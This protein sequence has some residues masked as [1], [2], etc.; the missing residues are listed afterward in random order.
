MKLIF[1]LIAF[2]L[3]SIRVYFSWS[4]KD[5]EKRGESVSSMVIKSDNYYEE[6][7]YSG[8]FQLTDDETGF[9]SI[10]P[11][12]Y[13]KFRK[14][15]E[16]VKAESNL[17]GEIEYRIYDGE[18]NLA[19]DKEGKKLIAEAIREMIVQGFDAKARMERIYKKG[20]SRALISEIDSMKTDQIK[21]IYLDRVFSSDSSLSEDLPAI[22]LKIGSLGSDNDKSLFL[23]R[24]PP[25]HLK[26]PQTAA[27]YFLVIEKMGS[28]M[29][30]AG[31]LQFILDQDSVT[32]EN[33]G[34]IL[35]LSALLGSDMD[36]ASL[37]QKM[38]S[39]GLINGQLFDSLLNRVSAIGSD[40]DKINLYKKLLEE[41]NISEDQW[42]KLIDK[43]ERLS[44]DMD[45]SNFL[46]IIASKMPKTELVKASYLEAAKTINNDSDYGKALRAV[47]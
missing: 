42:I 30:K 38:I 24:I 1:F 22:L 28:D 21:A 34:K 4:G 33:A 26:N 29:D 39:R 3:L 47:E 5:K 6:I 31:S 40:M 20:G 9:T 37:Y 32:V 8:K 14:N 23:K 46:I 15:E 45:K 44:S 13:F 2:S 36:K 17:K 10:S 18:K 27:A 35:V 41:K 19:L 25:D 11:G 7:K 12:G 43:T 16:S